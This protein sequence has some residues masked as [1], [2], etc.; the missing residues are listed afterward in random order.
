MD[1]PNLEISMKA[2]QWRDEEMEK[3]T[4]DEQAIRWVLLSVV[5]RNLGDLEKAKE[6]I[7]MVLAV[8]RYAFKGNFVDNWMCMFLLPL[9]SLREII[10]LTPENSTN[11]TL[12]MGGGAMERTWA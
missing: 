2:L 3:D 7:Q 12:R 5:S 10:G 4:I 9:R 1:K 8:D 11:G 6:Y